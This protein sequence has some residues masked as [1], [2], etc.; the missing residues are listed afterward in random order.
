[1]S[2]SRILIDTNLWL[3]LASDYRL[4]PVLAAIEKLADAG[5]IELIMPQLVLD[6]FARHRDRVA[7]QRQRSLTSHIKCVREAM[8]QFGDDD[9]TPDAIDQLN[10]IE[11]KVVMKGSVSRRTIETVERVMATNPPIVASDSAKLKVVERALANLAPFHRSKNSTVD[12]LLI[13]IFAEATSADPEAQFYFASRNTRDFSQ[14]NGDLRLPHADLAP[15]FQ[16]D[17]CHYS[18]SVIDVVRSI[19]PQLLAGFE[20][21]FAHYPELRGLSDLLEA[22]HLLEQKVWYDRHSIRRSSV[23]NGDIKIMPREQYGDQGYR[24]NVIASDIWQGALAAAKTVEE[25]VGREN[26]GPWSDFEWG[27]LNGKLS[28]LRWVLGEDWDM[29]DT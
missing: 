13:E 27:M 18:I 14:H 8:E 11:Q 5:A 28:A 2:V 15:I 26:L 24:P 12:G 21:E 7:E 3:D 1:M 9:S 6:E 25:E 23:E 20:G 17:N 29:L 16:A 10:E 19:A 4:T 22:E